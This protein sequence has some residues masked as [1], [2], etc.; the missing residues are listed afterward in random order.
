MAKKSSKKGY[1]GLG[2]VVSIIL[3][4]FPLT[5]IVFGIATRLTRG[6]ILGAVLNFFV[7]PVFYIIDLVTIITKEKITVLA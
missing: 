3:A 6:N 7:F 5:N 4:L 1:F 2:G